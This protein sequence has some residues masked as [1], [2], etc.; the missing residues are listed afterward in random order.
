MKEFIGMSKDK[1]LCEL[2]EDGFIEKEFKAYKKLVRNGK[3]VCRSCGRVARK[4][5]NLCKPVAL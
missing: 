2:K 5:G 4:K 1:T 3:Y